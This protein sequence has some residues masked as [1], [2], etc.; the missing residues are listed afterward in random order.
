MAQSSEADLEFLLVTNLITTIGLHRIYHSPHP[1]K[2]LH[3]MISEPDLSR[4]STLLPPLKRKTCEWDNCQENF[5][6]DADG[7][8]HFKRS[9]NPK[10]QGPCLWKDCKYVSKTNNM[11]NHIR[12][13][14]DIVEA[15]CDGC[16]IKFKWKSDLN[17]HCKIYHKN[18]GIKVHLI[19]IRGNFVSIAYQEP[20]T[21]NSIAMLLN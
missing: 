9:H 10:I 13:H 12:K 3:E 15:L 4:Y 18:E 14:F 1:V 21:L 19:K 6:N 5:D 7:F 20:N 11:S 2:S 8:N 16:L 17:K